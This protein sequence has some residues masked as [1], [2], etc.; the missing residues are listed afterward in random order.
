[1]SYFFIENPFEI[2]S[3]DHIYALVFFFLLGL[4]V[5][6]YAKT[7]CNEKTQIVIGVL[8]ALI[9]VSSLFIR[10][11]ILAGLGIFDYK[12]DLPLHLCRI[13]AIM[14]PFIM[15][16]RNKF[17]LGVLYF[18]IMVGTLNANLTPDLFY[19]FPH[20]EYLIYF[21]LHSGLVILPLYTIMVYG[22]KVQWRDMRNAFIL[23]NVY[24][25]IVH[26]LN[27]FL[28][29][30]YFYTMAKPPVD[31]LLDYMGPWPWYLLVGQGVVLVLMVVMFVPIW[32]RRRYN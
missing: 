9:P 11:G 3:K 12:L 17:F 15:Y 31:S 26:V 1:M 5:I 6:Y 18:W 8:L 19:G 27:Y 13:I 14:A 23:T 21:G 29:S 30:N 2:F 25:L 22:Y 32:I 4:G 28:G 24:M 10:M 7:Y 20:Y 16:Y